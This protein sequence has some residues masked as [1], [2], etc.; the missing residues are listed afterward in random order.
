MALELDPGVIHGFSSASWPLPPHW[1]SGQVPSCW[2]RRC[3]G[4]AWDASMPSMPLPRP[5]PLP[6]EGGSAGARGPGMGAWC[7]SAFRLWWSR[8]LWGSGQL[9]VCCLQE[10]QRRLLPAS[11]CLPGLH[12]LPLRPSLSPGSPCPS[13]VLC[14]RASQLGQ[15][16]RLGWGTHGGGRRNHAGFRIAF[17]CVLPSWG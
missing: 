16:L 3:E 6:L 8:D 14:H 11:R 2:S 5:A 4:Q 1:G 9:P 10:W 12:P 7:G 17:V 15:A 13:V